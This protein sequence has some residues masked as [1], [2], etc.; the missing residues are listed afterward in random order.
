[1][2]GFLY[3]ERFVFH[4]SGDFYRQT[5]SNSTRQSILRTKILKKNITTEINAGANKNYMSSLAAEGV[6]SG[7]LASAVY[8]QTVGRSEFQPCI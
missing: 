4:L 2:T 6:R 5:I 8:R 7:V 3:F 1:M